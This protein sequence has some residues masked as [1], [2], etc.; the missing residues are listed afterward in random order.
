MIT[1]FKIFENISVP[2]KSGDYA[3]IKI[4]KKG[5]IYNELLAKIIKKMNNVFYVNIIND[6]N[7]DL[8]N[9]EELETLIAT[10]KYNI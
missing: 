1:K 9:K 7:V 10:K 6:K 8:E 5:I 4:R 2:I 3:L